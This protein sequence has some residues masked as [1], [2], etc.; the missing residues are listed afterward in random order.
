MKVNTTDLLCYLVLLCCFVLLCYILYMFVFGRK[1]A[2]RPRKVAIVSM[3]RHPKSFDQ[4]LTYHKSIGINKFYIRL[5]DTPELVDVLRKDP[6]ITLE[7]GQSTEIAKTQDKTYDSVYERQRDLIKKAIEMSKKDDI[8]WLIHIDCDELI[9]C[10]KKIPN[11]I[12]TIQDAIFD[13]IKNDANV[14]NIIMEN[15]EAQYDKINTTSDSCFEYKT[16]VKCADGGCVSYANGKSIGK[17][18]KWLQEHGPHRFA[19]FGYGTEITA[20]NIRL[21]HFESCDFDQYMQKY[22]HLASKET[23]VYPFE[24]Y[25][26]SIKTV[27]DNCKQH[28]EQ[29]VDALKATYTKYKIRQN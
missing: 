25:N 20:K 14:F 26:E 24:F 7:T 21:L 29:C 4:W 18:S 10:Q 11:E 3:V 28:D 16:L 27:K 9:E 12:V 8:D 13:E 5:E 6:S 22:L 1:K 15:Y 17:L 23:K 19:H 2:I